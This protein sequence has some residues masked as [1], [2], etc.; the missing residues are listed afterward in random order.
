M[1]YRLDA[2][3][4]EQMQQKAR[5]HR[6]SY[7]HAADPRRQWPQV[8]QEYAAQLSAMVNSNHAL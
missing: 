2:L 6:Q 1:F 4:S 3:P 7:R 8:V 5:K